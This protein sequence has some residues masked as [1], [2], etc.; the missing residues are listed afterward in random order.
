MLPSPENIASFFQDTADSGSVPIDSLSTKLAGVKAAGLDPTGTTFLALCSTALAGLA[1]NKTVEVGAIADKKLDEMVENIDKKDNQEKQQL[2]WA[3]RKFSLL[4]PDGEQWDKAAIE[5]AEGNPDQ[6]VSL[7]EMYQN[8]AEKRTQL[9]EATNQL[10]A[11]DVNE[12]VDDDEDFVDYL[13]DTLEVSNRSDALAMYL[14]LQDLLAAKDVQETL[15]AVHGLEQDIEAVQMEIDKARDELQ[16]MLDRGVRNQGFKR[17][18]Q[19]YYRLNE[20]KTLSK[21]WRTGIRPIDIRAGHGI[22]RY[23]RTNPEDPVTEPTQLDVSDIVDRLKTGEPLILLGRPGAGKSTFCRMV[24]DKW[25]T[26]KIGTIFFRPSGGADFDD[27]GTLISAIRNAEGHVLVVV[28]DAARPESKQI[29]EVAHEFADA[30]DVSLLLNARYSEFAHFDPV[31]SRET[32]LSRELRAYVE[33]IET[34]ELAKLTPDQCL[35]L[36]EQFEHETGVTTGFDATGLF[37]KLYDSEGP[38]D[39][40]DK[41]G[42]M[43]QIVYQ[44]LGTADG[45]TGLEDDIKDKFDII[46][47]PSDSRQLIQELNDFDPEFRRTAGVMI[48]LLNA[49]P[50]IDVRPTYLASLVRADDEITIADIR[51]LIETLDGWM[52]FKKEGR[53]TTMHE[54]WSFLYLRYMVAGLPSI[55]SQQTQQ[56]ITHRAA[57]RRFA[58]CVHSLEKLFNGEIDREEIFF[59]IGSARPEELELTSERFGEKIL[60]SLY[61]VGVTKPILAPLYQVD[62]RSR[63]EP[64]TIGGCTDPTAVKIRSKI[65]RILRKQGQHAAAKKQFTEASR[66]FT[67]VESETELSAEAYRLNQ[68]AAVYRVQKDWGQSE[69]LSKESL[70]LARQANDP[71]QEIRA[72]NYLAIIYRNKNKRQRQKAMYEQSLELARTRGFS[73]LEASTLNNIGWIQSGEEAKKS[74][75]NALQISRT[76][77]ARNEE[78]RALRS[79]GIIAINEKEY[80]KADKYLTRALT[81]YREIGE[82]EGEAWVCNLLGDVEKRLKNPDESEQWYQKALNIFD[83]LNHQRG[84]KKARAGIQDL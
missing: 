6:I 70:R 63:I 83:T 56:P 21:A 60:P 41:A 55:N 23:V 27:P 53:L 13:Q 72:R 1:H 64:E 47:S 46:E 11:G 3:L 84:I 30:T 26:D 59:E 35:K 19:A 33:T 45:L 75:N 12:L 37:N 82:K 40:H 38:G 15:E 18:D 9:E 51:R 61:E 73:Q 24:I 14:D 62:G 77:G 10:I 67:S 74:H 57:H 50:D 65:G 49:A 16:Q 79:L 28:D 44:L 17:I 34:L 20:A 66:I 22:D 76:I 81:I 31:S 2:A 71:Q 5:A 58:T 69:R 68:Y 4:L 39:Q 25:E 42:S 80:T 52:I 36:L 29:Y 8:D 78:A 32:D 48:N 7:I 54:F 43:L